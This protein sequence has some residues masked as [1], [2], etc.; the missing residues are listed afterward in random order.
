MK[1][2]AA[3]IAG[4]SGGGTDET[5]KKVVAGWWLVVAGGWWLVGPGF[6]GMIFA[7]FFCFCVVFMLGGFF[8]GV[9]FV[10]VNLEENWMV[11]SSFF[12]I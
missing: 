8:C 9:I 2:A 11:V 6:L 3:A 7:V 4:K 12:S 1:F 5:K 10:G